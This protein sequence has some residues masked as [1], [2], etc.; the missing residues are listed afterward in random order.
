MK[1]LS[2]DTSTMMSSITIMEDNRIIGDYNISQEETHSEMLIPL[3]KRA[4]DDLKI[5]LD[6]IDLFAVASGPGSFTGLRIGMASI[7]AIAQVFD[8]PIVGVSTLEAMAFSILNN[9]SIISLIDARGKRYYT[10]M[11]KW[12]DNKLVKEF[13]EILKE[14][15]L[16]EI[17]KQQNSVTLVGEAIDV[18]SD[19]I[20]NYENVR[21]SHPGL[22]NGIGRNLC[23]IAK[24]RFE[25]ND[26]D[27]YFDLTP[28]YLR[29]SQAEINLNK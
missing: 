13:E 7:K 27:N 10:G 11:Y 24:E 18:L 19:E 22:N 23:V 28:S 25:N 29:K 1:I 20:K 5:I 15:E 12:Q 9:D 16:F 26:L 2:I 17:I 21:L 8:K 3:L 6:E 4:V 14:S